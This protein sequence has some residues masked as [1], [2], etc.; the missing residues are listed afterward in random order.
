M[1]YHKRKITMFR[2]VFYSK[3]LFL[4]RVPKSAWLG[5]DDH[6][7]KFSVALPFSKLFHDILSTYV[8][9]SGSHDLHFLAGPTRAQRIHSM[10]LGTLI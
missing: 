4:V 10:W 9:N 7:D 6:P 2:N 5:S 3:C 1:A 8:A